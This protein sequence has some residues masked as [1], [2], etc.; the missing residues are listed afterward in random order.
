MSDTMDG[1]VDIVEVVDE[2]GWSSWDVRVGHAAHHRHGGKLIANAPTLK[3]AELVRDGLGFLILD[4]GLS[5][6]VEFE[7]TN[8]ED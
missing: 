7:V 4:E 6:D 3:L 2:K 1:I 8:G 5:W